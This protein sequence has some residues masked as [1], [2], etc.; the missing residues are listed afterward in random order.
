LLFSILLGISIPVRT[1]ALTIIAPSNKA[2]IESDI[3]VISGKVKVPGED[4]VLIKV[5]GDQPSSYSV[6]KGAFSSVVKLRPGT[7]H[8][9][10]QTGA[11][12]DSL[13]LEYRVGEGFDYYRYH[14]GY[15]DG[16]CDECHST[17][18]GWVT[19]IRQD[20]L[21]YSCHDSLPEAMF[22]HGPIAA[23]QCTIC[24]DPHGSERRAFLTATDDFLCVQCHDQSSSSSHFQ[25]AGIDQCLRCHDPHGTDKRFFL[26][27]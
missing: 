3:A 24:H 4:T 2:I 21:C 7:N 1:S 23:G 18:A 6:K 9:Q 14:A 16:D 25:E 15:G 22:L 27:K 19:P 11:A 17:G 26:K 13:E 20:K 10:I 12:R 8:I 5:N